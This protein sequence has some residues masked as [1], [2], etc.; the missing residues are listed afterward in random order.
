MEFHV[1]RAGENLYD[2][3]QVEGIRFQD[4]LEMNQLTPDRQPALGERIY[5]QGV[6]AF[7]ARLAG[8]AG[9][10]AGQGPGSRPG[11]TENQR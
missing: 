11:T 8:M 1:V 2:I 3:S 5:L 6:S 7:E 4:M 10:A 9:A